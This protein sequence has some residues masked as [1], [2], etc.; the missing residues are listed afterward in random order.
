[1]K[2]AE[3]RKEV[4]MTE[5]YVDLARPIRIAWFAVMIAMMAIAGIFEV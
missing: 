1:M 3:T 4:K 2:R 5:K